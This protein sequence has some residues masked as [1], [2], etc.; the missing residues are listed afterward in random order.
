MI[1]LPEGGHIWSEPTEPLDPASA[2]EDDRG[3]N[4]IDQSKLSK[5]ELKAGRRLT[6]QPIALKA[7]K[8]SRGHWEYK[9]SK[10]WEGSQWKAQP[11]P[12]PQHE[13]PPQWRQGYGEPQDQWSRPS[14]QEAPSASEWRSAPSTASSGWWPS[15]PSKPPTEEA[16]WSWDQA[17]WWTDSESEPRPKRERTPARPS[18]RSVLPGPI[19]A[20]S[21][22]DSAPSQRR[23][24][25]RGRTR[26][27]DR[28]VDRDHRERKEKDRKAEK[29]RKADKAERESEKPSKRARPRSDSDADDPEELLRRLQ[30]AVSKKAKSSRSSY[31]VDTIDIQEILA[32]GFANVPAAGLAVVDSGAS[33]TVGSPEALM[34]IM[35]KL[36]Q[37]D[38]EAVVTVDVQAGR[39][40]RFRMADGRLTSA[41]SLITMKS[42]NGQFTAYCI[43]AEDTP[44]LLSIKAMREMKAAVCFRT[45]TICYSDSAGNPRQQVMQQSQRGHLLFDVVECISSGSGVI[46]SATREAVTSN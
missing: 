46:M 28:K 35:T 21:R 24:S 25:S 20:L 42:R 18:A 3:V 12:R 15:A 16:G 19:L 37:L 44:V 34:A 9:A 22:K 45:G 33:D 23:D 26:S 39:Q 36:R 32:A 17:A 27:R 40:V 4:N 31:G 29:E 2:L 5:K 6:G 38:P 13:V 7:D 30:K 1:A 11:D 43:E 8:A 41:H 10:R 14:W